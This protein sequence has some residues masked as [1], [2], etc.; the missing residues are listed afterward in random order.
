MLPQDLKSMDPKREILF[1]EGLAHPVR[2]AKIR[3]YADR[4][5]RS[6]LLPPVAIPPLPTT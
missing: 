1:C 6:R 2:C 5:Y 4:R 3:Y